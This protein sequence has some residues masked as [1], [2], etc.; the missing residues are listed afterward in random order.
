[1]KLQLLKNIL[2]FTNV[3]IHILAHCESLNQDFLT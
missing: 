2:T 1:M 3:D